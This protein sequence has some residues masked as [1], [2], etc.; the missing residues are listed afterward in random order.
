[1]GGLR[2]KR[3]AWKVQVITFFWT[4]RN[5][6]TIC[7]LKIQSKI[8]GPLCLAQ[9]KSTIFAEQWVVAKMGVFRQN[10]LVRKISMIMKS[11]T[12]R[13]LLSMCPLKF[14]WK[15][16]KMAI[17]F[18]RLLYD[19][20]R[21]AENCKLGCQITFKYIV[22]LILKSWSCEWIKQFCKI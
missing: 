3:P 14:E 5:I 7:P 20:A 15:K 12:C 13:N 9:V 4:C 19:G 22:A 2:Q 21:C 8:G 1:M 17:S 11:W 6:V 16:S 18:W 10:C